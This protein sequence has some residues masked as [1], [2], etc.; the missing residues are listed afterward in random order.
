MYRIAIFLLLAAAIAEGQKS[1]R[2]PVAAE[3]L[4]SPNRSSISRRTSAVDVNRGESRWY[5]RVGVVGAIYHSSATF[6]TGGAEIPDAGA[7]VSNNET[8]TFDVGYDITR[9]I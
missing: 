3:N 6:A 5:G 7:Q 8:V 4:A 2:R 9:N 1:Q